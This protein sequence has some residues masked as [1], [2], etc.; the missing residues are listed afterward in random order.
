MVD[1]ALQVAALVCKL[2]SY[3]WDDNSVWVTQSNTR[4]IVLYAA[5][6]DQI[7]LTAM[8]YGMHALSGGLVRARDGTIPI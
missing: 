5:G 1:D 3:D 4:I 8:I 7:K 6:T 2:S